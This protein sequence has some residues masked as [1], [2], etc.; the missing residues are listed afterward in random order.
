MI[1]VFGKHI[2]AQWT[3]FGSTFTQKLG[4]MIKAAVL[5]CF[6]ILLIKSYKFHHQL[7]RSS[8]KSPI[9]CYV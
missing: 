4:N 7:L 5:R 2:V 1:H 3:Y 8:Q 6:E 9:L